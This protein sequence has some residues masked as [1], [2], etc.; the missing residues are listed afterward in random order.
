M[1]IKIT[2]FRKI[3]NEIITTTKKKILWNWVST[4]VISYLKLV[5]IYYYTLGNVSIAEYH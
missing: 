5:L 3:K 4:I 1:N 2:N